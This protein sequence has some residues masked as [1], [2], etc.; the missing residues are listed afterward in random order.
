MVH[1]H[2]VAGGRGLHHVPPGLDGPQPCR[3]HL[4]RGHLRGGERGGV[5]RDQEHLGTV[6]ERGAVPVGEEHLIGDEHAQPA[7]RGEEHVRAAPG[8]RVPW[9]ELEMDQV[10]DE[11]PEGHVLAEWHPPHLLVPAHHP[12]VRR[13]G[14]DRVAEA[15]VARGLG[16]ARHHG[17]AQTTG[18]TG[19]DPGFR[20]THERAVEVD[21]V[22]GPD[23]QVHGPGDAGG[24]RDLGVEHDSL[25]V[26]QPVQT[27]ASAA[28]HGGHRHG[29]HCPPSVRRGEGRQRRGHDEGS[30]DEP[31][32]PPPGQ[33]RQ[34]PRGEGGQ[35]DD[36]QRAAQAGRLG[37][38]ARGLAQGDVAQG[39][40]PEGPACDHPLRQHQCGGKGEHPAKPAPAARRR[41]RAGQ[42]DQR[43]LAH[44]GESTATQVELGHPRQRG[45]V[46]RQTGGEAGHGAGPDGQTLQAPDQEPEAGDAH[47]PDAP[48][49][50]RQR[51]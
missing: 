49:R 12:A 29:A 23:H 10:P 41:G 14:H 22:L 7:C 2:A 44:G 43:G 47:G 15:G 4:L 46:P 6:A 42:R 17:G 28:L 32:G 3:R 40:T 51:H 34:R 5:R 50:H 30:R 38:R 35:P 45:Q 13:P 36:E 16:H 11:R 25:V 1:E 26:L 37:Q 8:K 31:T 9:D 24:G 48:G 27:T 39:L 33:L 19:H 21:D 20:G 18:Q